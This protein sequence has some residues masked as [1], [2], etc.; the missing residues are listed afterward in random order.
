M[1]RQLWTLCLVV[2]VAFTI[3][4]QKQVAPPSATAD[5]SATRT[6]ERL[7]GNGAPSGAHYSLNIIGVPKGKTASM[8]GSS[9][10]V[11]FVNLDGNTK[12]GLAQGSTYQVLDANGTDA[13]GAQFQL[14]NPDPDNDGIT[15]YSVWARPLGKPGGSAVMTTCAYDP[16][17]GED[18]C[19][20]ESAVFV[21]E[22]GKSTFTNVS[23]ELLYIYADLTD[24]GIVNVERYPLFDDRL[25]D[26]Y[27]SYDNNG[28]KIL[29]LRFYEE[30]TDV[31]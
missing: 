19:S 9:G 30:A 13:N 14:P 18:V 16:V 28:L 26:Y 20:L 7:T 4:C 12:I 10:H 15:E 27:W 31:N 21:R 29:Q 17:A 6:V 25:Q 5:N 3:G 11:I 23:R 1:K 24:D 2:P 8:T 22:K